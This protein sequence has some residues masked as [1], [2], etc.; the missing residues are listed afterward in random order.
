MRLWGPGG[1]EVGH[2]WFSCPSTPQPRARLDVPIWAR[3]AL[4]DLL[5]SAPHFSKLPQ[6]VGALLW[7]SRPPFPVELY[8]EQGP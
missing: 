1:A 7:T 2:S 6:M 3:V 8:P 4:L 5:S